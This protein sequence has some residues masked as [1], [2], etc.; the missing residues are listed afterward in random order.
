MREEVELA[1]QIAIIG[2]VHEQWNEKD[3]AFFNSS[4]YDLLLFVGDLTSIVSVRRTPAIAR[5]I[6]RLRKPALM[7]AGNH[8][9]HNRVQLLAEV[10][11]NARLAALTGWRHAA[12][13]RWLRDWIAPVQMGGYSS[14]FFRAGDVAFDV[15]LARP[16]SMGGARSAERRGG[17][18]G[19]RYSGAS[20]GDLNFVPM[21]RDVYGVHD[22]AASAERL[23]LCVDRARSGRIIFLAHNG[24]TG[25]GGA[26]DDLWGRD[27]GRN[28]G[29][30]WGDADLRQAID[31]AR[32]QGK[33]V[34]VVV[35]GHM[36]LHTKQGQERPWLRRLDGVPYVNAARVPRVRKAGRHHVRLALNGVGVEVEERF[37]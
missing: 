7:I 11:N 9:V 5:R 24:P 3:N 21:L 32:A 31:Y 2:D 18:V 10:L 25:L 6:G 23:R 16:C 8:D 33:Q 19:G 37:V 13:H 34:E 4:A 1:A 36:H 15:V 22:V 14:H 17:R 26:P 28:I 35:A 20:N 29:G 30:D 27:F 12:F